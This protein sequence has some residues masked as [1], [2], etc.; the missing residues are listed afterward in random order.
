MTQI[1]H[2]GDATTR[3]LIIG[4]VAFDIETHGGSLLVGMCR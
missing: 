2:R 1:D 4:N 3:T